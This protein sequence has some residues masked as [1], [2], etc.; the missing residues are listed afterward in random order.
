M[1]LLRTLCS[2]WTVHYTG[3][4][5]WTFQQYRHINFKKIIPRLLRCMLCHDSLDNFNPLAS[6]GQ[7]Q[8]SW[9][10]G[11]HRVMIVCFL[12]HQSQYIQKNWRKPCMKKHRRLKNSSE[13]LWSRI[14]YTYFLQTVSKSS[15]ILF[16]N[17]F[18]EFLMGQTTLHQG[19]WKRVR[20]HPAVFIPLAFVLY[21]FGGCSLVNTGNHLKTATNHTRDH[22]T[23]PT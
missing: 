11:C 1:Q 7:H 12:L 15:S 18:Y 19:H 23:M 16:T 2:P 21:F 10:Y 6:V 4:D 13:N 9:W 17:Y 22:H 8:L 14:M 5:G 3:P 20:L